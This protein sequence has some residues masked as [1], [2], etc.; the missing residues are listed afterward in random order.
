[1]IYL[2]IQSNKLNDDLAA[3]QL[4]G[5]LDQQDSRI[6]RGQYFAIAA[7]ACFGAG[8]IFGLISLYN[9]VRDPLPP[10]RGYTEPARDLD[11]PPPGRRVSAHLVPVASGSTAGLA[12]IGE[13]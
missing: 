1:G 5:R 4:A 12:L 8:A 3:A 10:S 11:A 13:F 7:D 2:G 9:F 6:K